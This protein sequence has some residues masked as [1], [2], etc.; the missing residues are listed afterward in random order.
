LLR[1]GRYEDELA[2]KRAEAE[3]EKQRVRQVE[4]VR[5]QEE[6]VANQEAKKFEIQKQIEAERRA[7]E[8]YRV[9]FSSTHGHGLA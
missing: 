9:L 4:L 3:H 2:R 1:R 8:Q 5:L 7:T 6:S